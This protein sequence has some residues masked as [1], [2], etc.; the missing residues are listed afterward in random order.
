MKKLTPE[1]C[2]YIAGFLDG[3]GSI[4]AQIVRRSEY[5]LHY[6]IRVSITFFQKTS[7][8]WFLLQLQKQ[9]EYGTIRKRPDGMSE[10]AIVG[11][12]SV[13]HCILLLKPY[14]QL[15]HRHAVCILQ[16]T[17]QLRKNQEPH[18]FIKLCEVVDKFQHLNDSKKRT[19][20]SETVRSHFRE[21][22]LLRV[23]VETI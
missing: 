17:K 10:Y 22:N 19:I 5:T 14:L 4:N 15:K 18:A 21:L 6:Q 3:D 23:P 11:K 16:I 9:L 8:H 12:Q 2:A 13:V 7:R 1:Q 20:T